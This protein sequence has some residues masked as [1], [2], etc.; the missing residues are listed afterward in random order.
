MV[1]NVIIPSLP[2]SQINLKDIQALEKVVATV[3]PEWIT[4]SPDNPP[5]FLV[6][7]E[8]YLVSSTSLAQGQEHAREP[9]IRLLLRIKSRQEAANLAKRW[10][11]QL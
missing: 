6:P 4:D 10:N 5:D 1:Y 2:T 7:V 9:L 11:I 3:P 8:D